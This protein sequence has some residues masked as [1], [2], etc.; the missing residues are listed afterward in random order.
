MDDLETSVSSP[1]DLRDT[2][3]YPNYNPVNG[4]QGRHLDNRETKKHAA[5]LK[6]TSEELVRARSALATARHELAIIQQQKAAR[7]AHEGI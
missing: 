5:E 4:S 3:T 1:Q 2:K 6:S 7:V